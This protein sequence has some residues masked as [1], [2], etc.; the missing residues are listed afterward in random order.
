VPADLVPEKFGS[1]QSSY[2]RPLPFGLIFAYDLADNSLESL[3]KN[4]EEY[5]DKMDKRM[6]PNLV[7]VLDKGIIYHRSEGQWETNTDDLPQAT[8]LDIV[9]SGETT[10][11]YFFLLLTTILAD[12]RLGHMNLWRYVKPMDLPSS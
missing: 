8:S 5:E 6:A 2:T 9:N 10:L 12:S 7:F 11:F 4:L 3:L 1:S